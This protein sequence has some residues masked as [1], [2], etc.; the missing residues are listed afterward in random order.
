[1]CV[2]CFCC[3]NVRGIKDRSR[4]SRQ[5]QSGSYY[6]YLRGEKPNEADEACRR[7]RSVVFRVVNAPE[8]TRRAVHPPRENQRRQ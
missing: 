1:M 6:R 7:G 2:C 3:Q 5:T 4:T 8:A